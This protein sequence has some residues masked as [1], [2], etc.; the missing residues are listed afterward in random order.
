[1]Q[2]SSLQTLIVSAGCILS[3]CGCGGGGDGP[4]LGD[5]S[6]VVR[7]DG[8]PLPD[9]TVRFV[10]ESGS[11]SV[12]VTDA[13]GRYELAYSSSKTGATVGQHTVQISTY[14]SAGEDESGVEM[15]A[16]PEKV[17]AE[18]NVNAAGNPEMKKEVKPGGNEINF[19]LKSGGE[20]AN[21]EGGG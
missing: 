3:I 11:P 16:V 17:A 5:V 14:R 20:I 9:A 21:R 13:E 6:G 2:H 1:M 10:P 15:P 4:E 8:Q 7:L 12:A 18:Y 19:D